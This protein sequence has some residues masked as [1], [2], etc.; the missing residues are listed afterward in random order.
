MCARH[1]IVFLSYLAV[2]IVVAHPA[3]RDARAATLELTGTAGGRSALYLV[4]AVATVV[5]AVAHKVPGDAAA[6]GARELVW[7]TGDVT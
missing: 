5:L 4:G 3:C 2:D 1:L 6:A 7:S